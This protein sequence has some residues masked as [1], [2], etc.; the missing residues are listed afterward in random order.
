MSCPPFW[1]GQAIQTLSINGD[2]L[3][4]NPGNS[5]TL[6][7]G[8]G[9]QDWSQFPAIQDVN[10]AN[11]GLTDLNYIDS[12]ANFVIQALGDITISSGSGV[13]SIP[14][15]LVVSSINGDIPGAGVSSFTTINAS[16]IVTSTI[17]AN[18]II[19]LSTIEVVNTVSTTVV[20]AEALINVSSING[21]SLSSLGSPADWALFPAV[22]DVDM[23]GN[24]INDVNS[25]YG[26]GAGDFLLSAG[27]NWSADIE[28]SNV[29]LYLQNVSTGLFQFI[30]NNSTIMSASLA[31]GVII[32]NIFIDL[33][34]ISSLTT[35]TINGIEFTGSGGGSI[36]L[37]TITSA[38]F[39]T[40]GASI[41]Q[42]LMS[43]IVFNPQVNIDFNVD[44]GLGGLAGGL[45]AIGGGLFAIAVAV[46][47]TAGTI[48]YGLIK[49]IASLFEPRPINNISNTTF[50]TF[51]FASQLQVS[52]LNEQVSTITRLVSTIPSTILINTNP[53]FST[54][55]TCDV[56]ILVSTLSPLPPFTAIRALG[57]PVA[58]VSSPW[59]VY[60]ATNDYS[61]VPLP[62]G[63]GNVSSV[64]SLVVNGDLTLFPSTILRS[65][66]AGAGLYVLNND[67]VNTEQVFAS[68][69]TVQPTQP[70]TVAGTFTAGSGIPYF[71]DNNF[72]TSQIQLVGGP[73]QIP[74]KDVNQSTV[75]NIFMTNPVGQEPS[76]TYAL[77]PPGFPSTTAGKINFVSSINGYGGVVIE[78]QLGAAKSLAITGTGVYA[79]DLVVGSNSGQPFTV[80]VP[81]LDQ[82]GILNLSTLAGGGLPQT[83]TLINTK[84]DRTGVTVIAA[85]NT[86]SVGA[87]EL[88][89]LDSASNAVGILNNNPQ[90][91]LDVGVGLNYTSPGSIA[92]FAA[93][94]DGTLEATIQNTSTGPNASAFF[95]AVDNTGNE[96][97]GFGV[98]S[99]NLSSIYNTLFEI[100]G[101]SIQ[102]GTLDCVIGPQSDHSS[103]SGIYLT[104]QD[105]A[106]AWHINSNGALSLNA[107]YNGTVNE[108]NFGTPG[109]ILITNGSAAAPDWGNSVNLNIV[110]AS[111]LNANVI[112]TSTAVTFGF[113][114][115]NNHDLLDVSV[116][117]V[118][119]PVMNM[120]VS[121]TPVDRV[122]T[123]N[124]PGAGAPVMTLR[125][126][127][128]NVGIG[129]TPENG[130]ALD[131]NGLIQ[132]SNVSTNILA[133]NSAAISSISQPISV[134]SIPHST[135]VL[136]ATQNWD[137][138]VNSWGVYPG[139]QA[140]NGGYFIQTSV[141]TTG[142][143][144]YGV[145]IFPPPGL[146]SLQ[147]ISGTYFTNSASPG[148]NT[149]IWVGNGT[150][151]AN[152]NFSTINV[153]GDVGRDIFV[154]YIGYV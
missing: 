92:S 134:D 44:L 73:V 123:L 20:S 97:A 107:S 106:S 93:A 135:C 64:S 26:T 8:G 9:A 147:T 42:G 67:G 75:T 85:P 56:E 86:S 124:V 105:G 11:N 45:A 30:Q 29:N 78:S 17:T 70:G 36:T 89:Y 153:Y 154:S 41:Q 102:S 59:N 10:M 150:T 27:N 13:V 31:D 94:R 101:A 25:I 49:G 4:I 66:T 3:S 33:A 79:T 15:N 132:G 139:R 104:Y 39:S 61:W 117:G 115:F 113:A 152:G 131:V 133:A 122:L 12:Q 130:V 114:D 32:P 62:S 28:G 83:Q 140:T 1:P 108:G 136:T 6:P 34:S 125:E 68:G 129:K 81:D 110:S 21:Q 38:A 100:P 74:Q 103:N 57:D 77:Y 96:Y 148:I 16:S 91:L 53:T 52:T 151:G 95:F 142:G 40:I 19:S 47:T 14:G 24:D 111:T 109:S 72:S 116:A 22:N 7:G 144:G 143:N 98:N 127:G 87:S 84:I 60:Q 146:S 2:V 80:L 63:G 141:P 43:S 18:T 137:Y 90:S 58:I 120:N 149:P 82:W 76:L 54:I 99:L 35:S 65:E 121:L 37:S 126:S 69:F 55:S 46:P 71:L 112:N 51:N 23:S 48:T 118:G 138:F 5:V 119:Y 50:E 145:F 128:S 88:I